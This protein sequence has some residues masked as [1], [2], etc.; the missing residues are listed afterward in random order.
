M[1]SG[2]RSLCVD[3]DPFAAG[4]PAEMTPLS[5]GLWQVAQ[6]V[7]P[8]SSRGKIASNFS[9]VLLIFAKVSPEG[10]AM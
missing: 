7:L 5:C 1:G 6:V 8:C 4:F 2:N 3:P 9:S 10:L